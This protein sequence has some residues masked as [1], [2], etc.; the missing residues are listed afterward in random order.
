MELLL[1]RT[2]GGVAAQIVATLAVGLP[3]VIALARRRLV[4]LVW[5]VGGVVVLLLGLFAFRA[6]R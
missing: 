2:D 5:F 4:E 3:V 6:V 1:P